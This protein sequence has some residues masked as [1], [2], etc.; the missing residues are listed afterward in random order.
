MLINLISQ[1]TP[2]GKAAYHLLLWRQILHQGV[3]G[4]LSFLLLESILLLQTS[5]SVTPCVQ[6]NHTLH[7]L[8]QDSLSLPHSNVLICRF[9]LCPFFE[10]LQP[11]ESLSWVS[12]LL[13]ATSS[14]G[15]SY[16]L[17]L[18]QPALPP[19]SKDFCEAQ[20][21]SWDLC[22]SIHTGYLPGGLPWE[23]SVHGPAL[24]RCWL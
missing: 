7:S 17:L 1:I 9:Y 16:D 19:A 12:A 6:T 23:K 21:C 11:G 3:W 24:I 10:T 18:G 2:A 22:L 4:D 20:P 8:G 15:C 13:T 5:R 14:Q